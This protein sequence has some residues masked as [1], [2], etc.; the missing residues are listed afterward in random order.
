MKPPRKLERFV[1][2]SKAFWLSLILLALIVLFAL[3]TFTRLSNYG[4][5]LTDDYRR[6]QL[7]TVKNAALALS[8]HFERIGNCAAFFR[9][10]PGKSET[11]PYLQMQFPGSDS[12]DLLALFRVRGKGDSAELWYGRMPGLSARVKEILAMP[13]T[14][15][16]SVVLDDAADS[17]DRILV[18]SRF[19]A[20]NGVFLLFTDANLVVK[21][22]FHL[23]G[24]MDPS[25]YWILDETKRILRFPLQIGRA[26]ITDINR[27]DFS[28]CS[29]CHVSE[30]DE[31]L[32]EKDGTHLLSYPP[33]RKSLVAWSTAAFMNRKWT[34]VLTL[35]SS[36]INQ[37]LND[38]L[39]A[40]RRYY[41]FAVVVSALF[42]LFYFVY[43]QRQVLLEAEKKVLQNDLATAERIRAMEA[44]LEKAQRMEGL[45]VLAG[46]LAHEINNPVTNIVLYTRLARQRIQ[47]KEACGD[48][49]IIERESKKVK[50]IVFDML[51]HI[52]R[53]NAA[54][55]P[56]NVNLNSL[57]GELLEI[58]TTILK[59]RNILVTCELLPGLPDLIAEEHK[60]MQVM[61]NIFS[62]AM[63]AVD[64][65]G[66]ITLATGIEPSRKESE[67][68]FFTISD[69]GTGIQ[70]DQ[71]DKIFELFYTTKP[72]GAGTGLGLPVSK[73]IVEKMGGKIS[74]DSAPGKG[75]T[76]KVI[77]PIRFQ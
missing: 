7:E 15:Q 45:S 1:L 74:L 46:G 13:E 65:G 31:R 35:P 18:V 49:E 25:F 16:S 56:K 44:A 12:A 48:L 76:V 37:L 47:D 64:E 67:S 69:T 75:T 21:Q 40:S 22:F 38:S 26:M 43:L 27:K 72:P 33:G 55:K 6:H 10:D 39:A 59:K 28:R 41:I 29:G 51:S 52:R 58:N 4:E 8:D 20:A 61:V 5:R 23:A 60:I 73:A 3:I 66:G 30:H 42:L 57:V 68:V 77:L 24:V 62:N 11:A 71:L 17:L 36:E 14:P 32:D 50:F 2:R 19:A 54:Q 70:P 63:D 53:T 9:D 34:I